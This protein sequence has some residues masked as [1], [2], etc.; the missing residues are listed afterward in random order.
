MINR[1]QEEINEYKK[2]R[3]FIMHH[4]NNCSVCGKVFKLGDNCYF[5]H[6]SNGSY[7]YTCS[8]CSTQ[9]ND[10]KVYTNYHRLP[11]SIP[12]PET[13]LWR[14]MDLAKFLSLLENQSLYFTRLDHFNDSFEGALGVST[15]ENNW[16]K[17]ELE[18]RKRLYQKYNI[19]GNEDDYNRY[20]EKEFKESRERMQNF[21]KY[22]Y[23]SCWHASNCESEAM[24]QLYTRDNK[25][26]VAI[27]TTF[28]RLYNSLPAV[29]NSKFGLVNYINFNDYNNGVSNKRFS[30]FDAPWY[31]RESFAHEREFR[32]IIEDVPKSLPQ[33]W[34][35]YVPININQLVENVYISP[36]SNVWFV[37][38]VKD[39]VRK[40]YN[41]N[42][43]IIQS[44]LNNLP[45]Y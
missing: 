10:A 44:E 16:T 3:W 19:F 8:G 42:V 13:K 31:K 27:Q 24:W 14:Y 30:A 26:G 9:L 23:V 34:E 7:A 41:L 11:F 28:M 35:K 20:I 29:I 2:L 43:N 45:F 25:Q 12:P 17:N 32:V 22:N 6:L 40:R 36:K 4:Y 39:I 37:N 33:D 21:R 18:V 15:N 5:G 38:L 1:F